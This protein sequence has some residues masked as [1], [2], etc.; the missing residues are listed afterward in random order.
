MHSS[1]DSSTKGRII[2]KCNMNCPKN[3]SDSRMLSGLMALS[4]IPIPSSAMFLFSCRLFKIASSSFLYGSL[5]SIEITS[6]FSTFKIRGD[7]SFLVGA[8]S[9]TSFPFAEP[10]NGAKIL[11]LP[12][13]Y[14]KS[15]FLLECLSQYRFSSFL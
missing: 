3:F 4:F 13:D 7:L 15:L 14:Q 1:S 9:I 8:H 2:T 10:S 5:P 6:P 11:H 12:E